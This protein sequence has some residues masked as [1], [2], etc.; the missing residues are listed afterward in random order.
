MALTVADEHR[1]T[2][3]FFP[4]PLQGQ[5]NPSHVIVLQTHSTERAHGGVGQ[6]DDGATQDVGQGVHMDGLEEAVGEGSGG[7]GG[8]F[9]IR[10]KAIADFFPFLCQA[11]GKINNAQS[12]IHA[13]LNTNLAIKFLSTKYILQFLQQIIFF[14]KDEV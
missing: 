11:L 12:S 8:G 9:T 14:T 4:V 3:G 13:M 7:L 1:G 5:V 10:V 6:H 2:T